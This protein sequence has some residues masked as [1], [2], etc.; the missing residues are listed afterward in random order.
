MALAY[1]GC[2]AWH[3]PAGAV[4]IRGGEVNMGLAGA[5]FA[6]KLGTVKR[7]AGTLYRELLAN[8]SLDPDEL[9]ALTATRA[10]SIARFAFDSTEFYRRHYTAAGVSQE[11]LHDPGSFAR[12][13]I[14]ERSHVKE[15]AAAFRSVEA[16]PEN[17]KD[18]L[19]GGSTGQPL[20]TYNDAR[21]PVLSLPWRMHSWWGVAP[22]ENIVHVGRWGVSRQ[23]RLKTAAT[24][25]PTKVHFVDAGDLSSDAIESLI[26]FVNS[27][28]PTLIEG[29][30]GAM[31]EIADYVRR[32]KRPFN[33]PRAIGVTAAPLTP[34]VRA[35]IESALGAPVFD[36]YRSS[37]I[38]YMAGECSR[39]DGLHVFSDMRYIEAVDDEG[40]PLPPG[41]V[42]NLV[43]TD[44]ANRVFPIIRYRLGDRGALRS[45]VCPCGVN[46][47]L[48]EPPDGRTV[49]MIRLPDGTVVGGGLFT[50][51]SGV[52][53]AVSLFQ[54]HQF[55]DHSI[56]LRVVLGS[57]PLAREQVEDVAQ[58]LRTRFGNQV[59]V[60]VQVVD[61]LPYTRGKL[62]YVTSEVPPP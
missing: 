21:V 34:E 39:Q 14:I 7:D 58:G 31:N 8:Q 26:A 62:K 38:Q 5:A 15:N 2:A 17:C 4:T 45:E 43:V 51:F 29:Y 24:W 6:L 11:D 13:P 57:S 25:W 1:A 16:T 27:R 54:L 53:D 41:E 12:L 46:L 60:T 3:S 61:E 44:L 42:G 20:A 55:A 52:P 37:E 32:L 35:R 40:V 50:L 56:R 22:H 23:N 49:D 19:T 9:A 28:R 10:A 30:V 33:P 47:P 48:M 18:S 59:P 36:Q